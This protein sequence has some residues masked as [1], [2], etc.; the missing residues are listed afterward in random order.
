MIS[1]TIRPVQS[2][3]QWADFFSLKR[4][5]YR[6]DPAAVIPLRRMEQQQVD[7]ERNPFYQHAEMEA[8][9]CYRDGEPVGR[10]AAIIDHLHQEYH[11]DDAGFFGFFEAIDDQQVV[12]LLLEQATG[13]LK[14]RS[15]RLIRGP[16][17][18]SLKSE[19]GVLVDGHQHSPMVMMAHT[20]A[21]YDRHLLEEGFDIAASFFAFQ[22]VLSREQAEFDAKV[23][24]LAEAGEKI[25][26]RFPQLHFRSISKTNYEA[27]LRDI[28]ELGNRVRSAGWGFVPLTPAELDFMIK[29]LR[30][31]IRYDMIHVAYWEDRLVGYI[32]NIPD[33]NWALQRTMGKW[34]WLRMIQLPFLIP[35]APRTRVI[36]L[37]VD[38]QFRTKGIAMLLIK[39]LADRHRAYDEWEFSWVH[40][41]NVKSLRAIERAMPLNHYKT[42][43]LYQRTI[44]S[45]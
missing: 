38:E 1:L 45:H 4:T 25:L 35:R 40:E 23:Q 12:H 3:R 7:R 16:V 36:A 22:L 17:N 14:D 15:C 24:P 42:Y 31:V 11:R 21:R 33:V 20:P 8:F 30:P 32:V 39:Q 41:N 26:K 18:P 6:D 28:N 44:E 34:D 37:G 19:F 29:N 5:L 10:I 43:R 27:A 13:W 2:A 9:V